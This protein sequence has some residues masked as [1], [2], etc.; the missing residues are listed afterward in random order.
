M[1]DCVSFLFQKQPLSLYM[2][3]DVL[4]HCMFGTFK[5]KRHRKHLWNNSS[6]LFLLLACHTY[7]DRVHAC[8][9]RAKSTTVWA[10]AHAQ[11]TLDV[12]ENTRKT[13]K[14]QDNITLHFMLISFPFVWSSSQIE[15]KSFKLLEV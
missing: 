1:S 12:R 11:D 3:L 14:E 15:S 10:T 9:C 7:T 4:M 5:S 13:C 2:V 6:C 8:S